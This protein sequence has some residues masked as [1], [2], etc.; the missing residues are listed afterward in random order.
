MTTLGSAP[1]AAPAAHG[2]PAVDHPAAHALAR[3]HRLRWWE[4]LPWILALAFYFTF[5]NYLGFGTELLITILFALSL[6]LALGYAG[7]ITLGHAAF[8]GVGAYTVGLLAFHGLWNEPIS[9]LMLAAIVAGIV[10]VVSG[11]VLLRTQGLTL[12]ML[13]LCTMAL[14]EEGANMA[15]DLTGGFDGLPSLPIPPLFGFF[16]FN[17]LFANTQYLYALAVLLVC[18]VYVRTLV[19]SPFGQSL[20]GI[21]ENILRMHAVGSPVRA[22]L[23][24]C[25]TISAA[26]A[27]VAGGLWA[28][29]NAYVNL[30]SLGLDRAATILIVLILGGH[31]RLYGA[32]VGAVAY[33]VLSHFLARIYPTAWQLGLGLALVIIA[34]FAR[35]GILGVAAALGRRLGIGRATP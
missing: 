14:L 25:Y 18:F 11:L 29:T 33:A 12:L 4:P 10:G 7:I 23:V 32:F 13:T 26:I 24:T 19:Y 21:R 17:P 31:G 34:L 15:H 30:G 2:T 20:T 22:R 35:N 8:F 9:S 16:E 28:Q 6:D 27:G 3:R 1:T 5:P